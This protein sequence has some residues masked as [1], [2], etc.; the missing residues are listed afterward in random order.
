MIAISDLFTPLTAAQVQSNIIASLVTLGIPANTWRKGGAYSSIVAV[1]A[2]IVAGFTQVMSA[3]IQSAFLDYASGGWLQLLAY[4]VY[5]VTP[6]AATFATGEA[7]FTNTGGGVFDLVPG[8]CTIKNPTTSAVYTNVDELVLNPGDVVTIGVQASVI[9]S[10]STSGPGAITQIVTTMLG[11]TVTN[12]AS[13]V[14]NDIEQDADLQQ[15]CR[16]SRGTSSARGPRSTYSYWAKSAPR[17]DGSIVNINRATQTPFSSTGQ[18]TVWCASP[19]G[20]PD[21]SDL[22]YADAAMRANSVPDTVTLTTLAASEVP[23]TSSL[24]IWA[25]ATAGLVGA[26]V[27]A[28]AQTALIAAVASYPISGI[29][30]PPTTQGYLYASFVEGICKSV[31]PSIFNV[32]GMAADLALNAGQVATYAVPSITVRI[33]QVS[34]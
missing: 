15:R 13:V 1:V 2:A 17:A 14:G 4:Y 10:A 11:V 8:A 28:A 21:S 22:A 9:G 12:A 33:V 25:K 34:S 29:P 32:T 7:T 19:S 18:V 26:D 20:A 24:V 31:H 5:G 3:F 27:A 6:I 23:L 30:T 16:D